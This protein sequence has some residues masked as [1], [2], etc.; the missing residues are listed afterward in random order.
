[1]GTHQI[2]I[3]FASS[4][5]H[6]I[7]EVRKILEKQHIKVEAIDSKVREIQAETLEE[8]AADSARTTADTLL[9]GVVVEDSGLFVTC[10]R[11][12]PGPYSS[13]VYRAIGCQGILRLMTGETDRNAV[14]R[15]AVSYCDPN[16]EPLVFSGE[17]KGR[18]SPSEKNGRKFGYDPVFIPNGLDGRTFSE[19]D[20]GEKNNV[21]H[22]SKAFSK[23]ASWLL[24]RTRKP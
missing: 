9:K 23:L 18:I 13:Y 3:N 14:F 2:K 4:N 21:S 16:S 19:L 24:T 5:P 17:V 20:I 11:G 8:I 1:M 10:L 22:R 12:F 15:S 7:V 6:K